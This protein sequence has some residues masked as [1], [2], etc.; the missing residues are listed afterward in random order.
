MFVLGVIPARGGSKGVPRKNIHDLYGKPLIQYSIER[1]KG[2]V[3]INRTIISTDDDEIADVAKDCGGDVPFKRPDQLAGD[4]SSMINVLQHA[5][6]WA[7]T[8]G[9]VDRVDYIACMQ[10]TSPF[11]T[12][13]HLD[14]AVQLVLDNECDAMMSVK[15]DEHTPI[16]MKKIINGRLVSLLPEDDPL[17]PL[18]NRQ[19]APYKVYA[20]SGIITVT[21]RDVLMK[22]GLRYG[23]NTIPLVMDLEDSINI[24][25]ET[26]F[27]IAEQILSKKYNTAGVR[28]F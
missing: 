18:Q 1:A 13:A 5:V 8:E 15:E 19:Q 3:L 11:G 14:E 28:R 9:G 21:K 6:T 26:D 2:S 12:A 16:Y 25:V 24:D 7:E 4:T 27:Y 20:P 23:T 10:P 17:K 22:Q